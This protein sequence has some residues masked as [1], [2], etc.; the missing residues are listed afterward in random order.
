MLRIIL[1]NTLLLNSFLF[2]K[3]YYSLETS[4]DHYTSKSHAYVYNKEYTYKISELIWEAKDVPLVTLQFNAI[5]KRYFLQ[6]AYSRNISFKDGLMNDYDWLKNDSSDWSDWSN[7]PNTKVKKIEKYNIA[8]GKFYLIK[9]LDSYVK[10][11]LGYRKENKLFEAYDGSYIYSSNSGFRDQIGTI[12]GLAISYKE[13]FSYAY[14]G[15]NFI[16]IYNKFNLNFGLLYAPFVSIKNVD[17]HHISYF[18]DSAIFDK[19]TMSGANISIQYKIFKNLYLGFN[20]EYQR[21][22]LTSG[23]RIRDWYQSNTTSS[24][25]TPVIK[26]TNYSY[27]NIKFKYIF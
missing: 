7:H 23:E 21:Y 22:K 15:L 12:D 27:S 1:L 4:L 10:S 13:E 14:M 17:H 6:M 5:K 2:S 3:T 16:K 18:I 9:S 24:N 8:I 11:S 20:G 25:A 26:S 19:T